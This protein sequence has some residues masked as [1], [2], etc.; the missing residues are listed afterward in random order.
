MET[1]THTLS[2]FTLK[3]GLLCTMALN[4]SP[5]RKGH[6]FCFQCGICK[7]DTTDDKKMSVCSRCGVVA[8]CSRQ[9]QSLSWPEH[10]HECNKLADFPLRLRKYDD[11]RGRML[12]ARRDIVCGEL[13]WSEE[14]S[15]AVRECQFK[16]NVTT[17]AMD[18]FQ[19]KIT[20][21]FGEP[22]RNKLIVLVQNL[23][24]NGDHTGGLWFLVD[25]ALRKKKW[26]ERRIHFYTWELATA[27][28]RRHKVVKFLAKI[29]KVK[30]SVVLRVFGLVKINH[31]LIESVLHS[32][33]RYGTAFYDYAAFFN[34]SCRPNMWR[35]YQ[36]GTCATF[37][38]TRNIAKGEPL[39][40]A[41]SENRDNDVALTNPCRC[42]QC[43]RAEI[44]QTRIES[45]GEV[46]DAETLNFIAKT[47]TLMLNM[48]RGMRKPEKTKAS[49]VFAKCVDTL[50]E[51]LNLDNAITIMC[52]IGVSIVQDVSGLCNTSLGKDFRDVSV[53]TYCAF[54]FRLWDICLALALKMDNPDNEMPQHL[55][56]QSMLILATVAMVHGSPSANTE[57]VAKMANF[58]KIC[59]SL[60]GTH[61]EA[62]SAIMIELDV[63]AAAKKVVAS[64]QKLIAAAAD[65]KDDTDDDN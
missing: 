49:H 54:R 42:G 11:W 9:C 56:K 24:E 48:T 34:Y 64:Y 2:I 43:E 60:Y 35:V 40:L 47:H 41:Y 58:I 39:T 23:P 32:N 52:A 50:E 28:P 65:I 37:H 44:V 19:K 1:H 14:P 36:N 26:Y 61:I 51:I 33:T 16:T 15:I 22:V 13:I 7:N 55:K 17:K 53:E 8:Y 12:E 10:K 62:D 30:A 27:C 4:E 25:A 45:F 18:T 20:T 63:F 57:S 31:F 46:L 21:L 6:P 5:I 29:H 59:S 3:P 38:A